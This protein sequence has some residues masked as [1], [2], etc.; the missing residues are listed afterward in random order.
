MEG[1]PLC[2]FHKNVGL[3]QVCC[4][5]PFSLIDFP[6][7]PNHPIN[8]DT[9]FDILIPLEKDHFVVLKIENSE[10]LKILLETNP[11]QLIKFMLKHED[12]LSQDRVLLLLEGLLKKGD[13]QTFVKQ[14]KKNVPSEGIELERKGNKYFF[15]SESKKKRKKPSVK[16]I[17]SIRNLNDRFA[18]LKSIEKD[19][20]EQDER[21]VWFDYA[22]EI[23]K[24]EEIL[25]EK[26]IELLF[27]TIDMSKDKKEKEVR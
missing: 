6:T 16:E 8:I 11:A 20:L 24:N 21:I 15:F 14:V 13:W 26:R 2:I 17:G 23:I 25:P 5:F 18:A 9:A 4:S 1:C 19:Q 3:F 27:M 7:Q 22:L 12:P 10:N